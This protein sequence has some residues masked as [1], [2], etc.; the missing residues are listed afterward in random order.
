MLSDRDAPYVPR[1]GVALMSSPDEANDKAEGLIDA[2]KVDAVMDKV[3]EFIDDKTGG[4]F[5]EQVDKVTDV[6]RERFGS[7]AD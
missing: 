7:G 4:K 3:E 6:V 2:S 5:A 1:R